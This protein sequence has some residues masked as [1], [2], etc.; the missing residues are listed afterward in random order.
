MSDQPFADPSLSYETPSLNPSSPMRTAA[1]ISLLVAGILYGLGGLC[2]GG[3]MFFVTAMVGAGGGAGGGPVMPANARLILIITGVVM[4][5][6]SWIVGGVYIWTAFL[7]RR[8]SRAAAVTSLIVASLNALVF[9]AIV[10][11]GTIGALMGPGRDRMAI[12]GVLFYLLPVAANLWLVI[13][14]ALVLREKR[15]LYPQ[16]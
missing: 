1:W 10:V 16:A 2:V 4:L 14:L 5:A 15:I 12:V 3:S 11:L 8:G 7:V 6:L 13:A 9:L